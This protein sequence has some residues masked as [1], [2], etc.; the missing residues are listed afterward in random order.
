MKKLLLIASALCALLV[1]AFA[2]AAPKRILYFT[3]G[4]TPTVGQ[5]AEIA[6]LNALVPPAFEVRILNGQ[7]TSA[8]KRV[9]ADYVAGAIPPTYRD[10][11][12]DSGSSLYTIMNPSN[13]PT[14][15]TLPS[16]Q[17]V[18]YSGQALTVGGHTYTFTISSNTI[19]AIAYQ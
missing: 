6:K 16:T 4:P 9:A 15:N 17:A 19:T 14:P 13:P 3:S 5:A 8:K 11:G 2:V 1:A 12:V 7:Q 10:G 18:V